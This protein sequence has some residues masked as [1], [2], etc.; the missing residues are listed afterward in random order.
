MHRILLPILVLPLLVAIASVGCS[1]APGVTVLRV[2]EGSVC[3]IRGGTG[4]CTE[5]QP[6]TKLRPGDIIKTDDASSA[7]ITFFDGTTVDLEAGTEIEVESLEVTGTGSTI[8]VLKQTIGSITFR[9]T[10]IIDPGSTYDV[11]TPTG[12]ASVRGSAVDVDVSEDGTTWI[13]NLEG[14]IWASAQGVELH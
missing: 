3:V 12:V 10:K 14:E 4:D 8:I 6:N 7:Q 1:D 13:T 11:E 2:A 5:V 9:V